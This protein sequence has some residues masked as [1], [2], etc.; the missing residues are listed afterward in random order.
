MKIQTWLLAA[1]AAA[2]LG[3]ASVATTTPG[4]VPIVTTHTSKGQDSRVMFLV[5][6]YTVG[7][8]ASSLKVLTEGEVSAHYLL[9]DETP[10]RILR[11]VDETQRAWHSGPSGW[12]P[13]R[14]LNASSIGIE[15]VHPGYKL[16]PDGRR[17][18]QPF[19]PAQMDALI[20]LVKDI[21]AR[22]QIR[23]ERILG[24]GEV[25][26]AYKEDPGPTFPWQ[27]LSELGI[28]PPWP[29][30][31]RVARLKPLFDNP[32]PD[33]T[34]FQAALEQH[35][36]PVE[37]TGRFDGLTTRVLLNFQMRYRNSDWSGRPDAE[38]A[39]LLHVLT[40]PP[41]ADAALLLPASPASAASA[42]SAP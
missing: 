22:H 11:L 7:D 10:P 29:D 42:A 36:Y 23:P 8:F 19:P 37:R 32:L 38:T 15:I 21:V 1:S 31:A 3:C 33:A 35:G 20:P 4:G 12:G 17:V 5:I 40:Q 39:A 28:T 25:T 6:H 14:R 41:S 16:G 26:P 2:L 30:A 18:Y 9:T 27:R 24:H 13:N 34:W